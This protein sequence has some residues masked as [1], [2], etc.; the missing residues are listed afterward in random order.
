M[1]YDSVIC[2]AL[3]VLKVIAMSLKL[4]VSQAPVEAVSTHTNLCLN[5]FSIVELK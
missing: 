1:K 2:M 5:Y 3:A 4:L